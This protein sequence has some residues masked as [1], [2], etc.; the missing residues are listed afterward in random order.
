MKFKIGLAAVLLFFGGGG[1][2]AS[3]KI[4]QIENLSQ[5]EFKR[6]SED[7]GSAVGYKAVAPVE[8]LG[9]TGFDVGIVVTGTEL[10]EDNLWRRASSSGSA[11]ST[12]YIPK[13]HVH[14]GLP[15]GIDVGAFYSELSSEDMT[16]WGAEVRYAILEG[17]V[18]V[19][20]LGVRATAT[21]L[22]G[23]SQ[24]EVSTLGLDVGVSKGFALLTLYGGAGVQLVESDV[25]ISAFNS[26]E[27]SQGRLYAGVNVNFLLV[28]LGLEYDITGGLNSFSAKAGLRF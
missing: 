11:P 26:E 9:I 27:F 10:D 21:Q 17:G 16:L 1:A 7:L 14:K 25:N 20:A 15:F 4:D 18:A 5:D 19:P 2:V 23:L 13:L 28:N 6:L 8:P 3:D 12:I 24:F 22:S